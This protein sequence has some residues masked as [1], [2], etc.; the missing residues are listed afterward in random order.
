MRI[1][2]AFAIALLAFTPVSAQDDDAIKSL[3]KEGVA[4]HDKGD[5]EGALKMYDEIL[6]A[7]SNHFTTLYEKSMTLYIMRRF[8]ECAELCQQI[9]KKHSDNAEC[10]LVYV[11]YGSALDGMNKP[12]KAIKIYSQG[13]KKFPQAYLLY[14][15]RG[16]TQY[17]QKEYEKAG[18]DFKKSAGLNPV[19][20]SSHQFLAYS[21]YKTNKIAAI[22]SL[23][24]FLVLEREGPRATKNLKA[25]LQLLGSNVEKTGNN[26][27]TINLTSDALDTKERGE[28]DFHMTEF[29][30][31]MDAAL[32]H[33]EKRKDLDAA[34]RLKGKLELIITHDDEVKRK[35]RKGFFTTFYIPFLRE[36]KDKYLMETAAYIMYSS[37][38]DESA[39]KWLQ[40]NQ[41]KVDAFYQWLQEYKWV[42]E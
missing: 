20:A 11:N 1:L 9:L 6:K 5:Y 39:K 22:M 37:S 35:N 2:I 40:A 15:N 17:L 38:D 30:L 36:M 21:I 7:N 4:L 3:L 31:T 27:V 26:N 8:D 33:D 12:E 18:E 19:H 14:F 13:I 10:R 34:Q 23:S 41:A 28:D 29:L 32:D 42:Q 25:L 16:V 24:T